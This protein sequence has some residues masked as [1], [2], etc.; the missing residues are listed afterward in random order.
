MFHFMKE[1]SSPSLWQ[2]SKSGGLIGGWIGFIIGFFGP[3]ALILLMVMF[4]Q[5]EGDVE[6]GAL[7]P[8]VGIVLGPIGLVVGGI[9]GMII[10]I[11]TY[12]IRRKPRLVEEPPLIAEP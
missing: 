4:P 2:A 1:R 5:L 6:M 7:V 9:F 12:L 3:P 11:F 10:G 8:F